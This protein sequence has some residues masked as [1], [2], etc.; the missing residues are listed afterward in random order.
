MTIRTKEEELA[1]QRIAEMLHD[2]TS[3]DM[4][5]TANDLAALCFISLAYDVPRE[6]ITPLFKLWEP[7]S[8][9]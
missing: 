7:L 8:E 6:Y 9:L 2:N 4:R 1:V 5:Q 3:G